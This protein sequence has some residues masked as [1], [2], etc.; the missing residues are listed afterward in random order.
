MSGQT[1]LE[2][3]ECE[4]I[5]LSNLATD[6]FENPLSRQIDWNWC[7]GCSKVNRIRKPSV[8]SKESTYLLWATI[9][10][11]ETWIACPTE[12]WADDISSDIS[13]GGVNTSLILFPT[14]SMVVFLAIRKV[15]TK[16]ADLFWS[17]KEDSSLLYW[18]IFWHQ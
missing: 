6:S 7:G 1:K 16:P 13:I 5:N 18:N 17:W 8:V 15:R 9:D 3:S 11:E 12:T 4:N 2:K 14:L 10:L